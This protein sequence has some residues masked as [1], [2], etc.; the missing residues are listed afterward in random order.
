MG[1]R[2]AAVIIAAVL[3][4]YLIARPHIG[5]V[6]HVSQVTGSAFGGP[7]RETILSVAYPTFEV[8]DRKADGLNKALAAGEQAWVKVQISEGKTPRTPTTTTVYN[9]INEYALL[10][11]W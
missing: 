7:P 3:V 2:N 8:C 1:P 6:W 9:C 5:K 10:W 11:G 4:A